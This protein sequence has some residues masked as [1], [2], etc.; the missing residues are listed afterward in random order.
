MLLEAEAHAP[1]GRIF[2]VFFGFW[3]FVL[4]ALFVGVGALLH[5]R[6]RILEHDRHAGH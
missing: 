1:F 2:L 6:E 3:A 4:V 5:K